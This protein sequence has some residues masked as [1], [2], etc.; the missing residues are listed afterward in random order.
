MVGRGGE[1]SHFAVPGEDIDSGIRGEVLVV[2]S[3]TG[4]VEPHCL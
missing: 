4:L 2:L 1:G 3:V